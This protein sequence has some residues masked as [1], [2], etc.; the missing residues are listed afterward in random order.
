MSPI[1]L[2]RRRLVDFPIE[3]I[4]LLLT[5]PTCNDLQRHLT[6]LL[7]SIEMTLLLRMDHIRASNLDEIS[8]LFLFQ[9]YQIFPPT[10]SFANVFLLNTLTLLESKALI[11]LLCS[12]D[13]SYLLLPTKYKDRTPLCH[14]LIPKLL[15]ST[16][17]QVALPP[18]L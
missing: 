13:P 14:L 1:V 3:E 7:I 6:V 12:R 16:T 17:Y 11:Y 10:N 4:D 8:V 15:L 5:C 18:G 9:T 2:S